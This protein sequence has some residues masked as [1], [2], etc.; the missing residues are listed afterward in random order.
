M[1]NQSRYELL[2]LALSY[3]HPELVA[4]IEQGRY[5]K[6]FGQT[7]PLPVNLEELEVEYCRLF[8][9]PGHVEVPPY[10]SVYREHDIKMQKG[11]V[12]GPPAAAVSKMYQEAGLQLARGFHD[13][14]D[15]IAAET[16]FLAYLE[17]MSNSADGLDFLQ[18]KQQFIHRHLGHWAAAF[19]EAV[20]RASRHAWYIYVSK[21]LAETIEAEAGRTLYS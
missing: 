12:M 9:G 3:P 7:A 16:W 17:A 18:R 10:E 14:P 5:D 4:A 21:L 11:L 8:V 13:M 15:H 1:S 2:A 20:Q 19:A 6:E